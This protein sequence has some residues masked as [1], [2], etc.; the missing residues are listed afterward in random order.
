MRPLRLA[1]GWLLGAAVYAAVGFLLLGAVLVTVAA[2]GSLLAPGTGAAAFSGAMVAV[3]ALVV[4]TPVLAGAVSAVVACVVYRWHTGMAWW[5]WGVVSLGGPALLWLTLTSVAQA[6]TGVSAQIQVNGTSYG[7]P[8][9]GVLLV[10]LAVATPALTGALVGRVK[11]RRAAA[12]QEAVWPGA[13]PAEQDDGTE[14]FGAP[15]PPANTVT[16]AIPRVTRGGRDTIAAVA[17]GVIGVLFLATVAIAAAPT[18][19]APAVADGYERVA[20]GSVS[21]D[22][23]EG[24]TDTGMLSPTWVYSWSSPEDA[25]AL[26]QIAVSTDPQDGFVDLY[27]TDM[28][29]NMPSFD[30]LEQTTERATFRYTGADGADYHGVLRVTDGFAVLGTASID[31]PIDGLEVSVDSAR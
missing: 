2:S 21:V 30:V 23:P 12:L 24:L 27:V 22:V 26:Q 14:I 29:G 25:E 4:L 9:L 20:A 7:S 6:T 31:V 15:A 16:G 8:V 28:A 17:A 3:V 10:V 5:K 13:A 1:A 19:L 11:N 18:L